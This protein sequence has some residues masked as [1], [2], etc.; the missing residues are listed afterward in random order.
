MNDTLRETIMD[1]L[2]EFQFHTGRFDADEGY[3]SQDAR[4]VALDLIS[5]AVDASGLTYAPMAG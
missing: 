1:I 5:D 2:F 3:T 4:E